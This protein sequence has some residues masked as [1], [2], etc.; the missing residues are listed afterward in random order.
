MA[1]GDMRTY[2]IL[3]LV[4]DSKESEIPAA[5]T[6][7]E[8]IVA[9]FGGAFLPEETTEKRNLAYEI[10]KER[11]GT[12]M[13]RRFTLPAEDVMSLSPDAPEKPDAISEITR[14]LRLYD[15]IARFMIVRAE[16]LPELKPIPRVE[17]PKSVRRDDRR[18]GR[19]FADRP[20][21]R[22][23]IESVRDGGEASKEREKQE[24]STVKKPET[25]RKPAAQE[26]LDKQLKEVL[27]I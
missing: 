16:R 14:L 26:D 12:Y 2:E 11:R 9:D 19:R 23:S 7:V 17:R 1:K 20:T 22:P 4:M 21:P 8:K 6:E 5:R 3:Y 24:E 10:G 15:A 27:D 13:A 18:G 25:K